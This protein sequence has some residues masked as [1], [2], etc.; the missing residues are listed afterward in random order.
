V[1]AGV[2][3]HVGRSPELARYLLDTR[4]ALE[5]ADAPSCD[6]RVR[7]LLSRRLNEEQGRESR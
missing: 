6:A 3:E 5:R 4:V 2:R 7:S 1:L